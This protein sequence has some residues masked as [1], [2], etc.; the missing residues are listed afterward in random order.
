MFSE[1]REGRERENEREGEKRSE[2]ANKQ[3]WLM[4]MRAGRGG[5]NAG[6]RRRD[7]SPP[8]IRLC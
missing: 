6:E 3:V 5:G 4:A 8:G 7:S 1:K 2:R